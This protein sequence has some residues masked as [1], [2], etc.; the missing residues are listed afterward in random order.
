MTTLSALIYDFCISETNGYMLPS[1]ATPFQSFEQLYHNT[2]YVHATS[3]HSTEQNPIDS[4]IP[5]EYIQEE[6]VTLVHTRRLETDPLLRNPMQII[7]CKIP[8]E[9]CI[10]QF[11]KEYFMGLVKKGLVY[12]GAKKKA[13]VSW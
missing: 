13:V 2:I 6:S 8:N 12:M 1:Q 4:Y 5:L 7:T 11:N 10:V 9:E 3:I